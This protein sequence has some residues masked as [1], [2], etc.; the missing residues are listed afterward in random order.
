MTGDIEL[1]SQTNH[2]YKLLLVH[3]L[4]SELAKKYNQGTRVGPKIG[5][6]VGLIFGWFFSGSTRIRNHEEMSNPP[7]LLHAPIPITLD[8]L[9]GEIDLNPICDQFYRGT[10]PV[11]KRNLSLDSPRT[12]DIG[13]R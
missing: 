1:V 3:I 11:R 12:L 4:V 8:E 6:S 5:T 9:F 2:S 13:L 10:S 7:G